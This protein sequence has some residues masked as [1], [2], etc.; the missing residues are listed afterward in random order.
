MNSHKVD[1]TL[2]LGVHLHRPISL[3]CVAVTVNFSRYIAMDVALAS[4]TVVND[5]MCKYVA[6]D[7]EVVA[8]YF[9]CIPPALTNSLG[10]GVARVLFGFRPAVD[11]VLWYFGEGAQA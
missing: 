10:L 5:F 11:F 1:L 2:A 8:T 7:A 4:W 6:V 9:A 3:M